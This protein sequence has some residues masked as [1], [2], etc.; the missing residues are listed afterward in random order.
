[1]PRLLFLT[2]RFPPDIGGLARSAARI[3][4]SLRHLG[5]EVD[6]VT[7]SRYL[8]PGELLPPE[9]E[10]RVFRL[11]LYRH[12][13]MTL[14][15]TLNALDWLH[16]RHSYDAIWGHYVFPAGFV[17][18]W[19]AQQQQIPHIVS[20]RGNDIDRA[21]FPPGDFGRLHWTL[22]RATALTAVSQDMA[23]KIQ[24]LTQRQD[25]QVM[26]NVVD[27]Q[28]FYPGASVDQTP[29][30]TIDRATA[31][32]ALGA[33]DDTVILGFAGELREKKGQRFL[34]QALATVQ[35]VRPALLL[36]VGEL[37]SEAKALLQTFALDHPEAAQSIVVTGALD[38]PAA[39][40]Q[41]LN[42]CDVYLQPSLWEG[43]PNALLEAMACGLCCIASDAG[44]I[45][46]VIESGRTGFLVPR[47]ALHRLGDVVLDCL[48]LSAAQRQQIGS[49]AREH[50]L[51]HHG[52][53]HEHQRLQALLDQILA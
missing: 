30:Q 48:N 4:A 24:V 5:V 47:S 8:Q 13:D 45:P 31:R 21:L 40:A 22:S 16:Q 17:G 1:M 11:G 44:G 41:Q 12:W 35:A 50:I 2:E 3:V 52:L 14:P 51:N 19:F 46:E 9:G 33:D 29:D 28:C 32:Q 37:R 27:A 7:W 6:V 25:V 26:P 18:T 42:L 34:L 38:S 36:I 49:A 20:A 15:H 39:V 23:G 43:L 10:P 53:S